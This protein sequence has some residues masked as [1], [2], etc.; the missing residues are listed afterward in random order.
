MKIIWDSKRPDTHRVVI[1]DDKGNERPIP[2]FCIQL[3]DGIG[4]STLKRWGNKKERE[5]II[6]KWKILIKTKEKKK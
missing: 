4:L 6:K 5:A 3:D 1:I 2:C